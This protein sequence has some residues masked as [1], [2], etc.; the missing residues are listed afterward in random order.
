[1]DNNLDLFKQLQR[2]KTNYGS[3]TKVYTT[4]GASNHSQSDRQED[5]YYATPP[6]AV[7]QLLELENFYNDILEPCCG[8]G[9]ISQTLIDLGYNVE[10]SDLFDRGF[11]NKTASIF[12]L[13]GPYDKDII[14]N[15]PY[16]LAYEFVE[17][18]LELVTE[19]HKVAMFLKLTFLETPRRYYLFKKYPIK[20]IYVSSNRL[21][22]AKNG[23]FKHV[24]K[25]GELTEGSAVCYAWFIW[26]KGYNGPTI[27]DHFNYD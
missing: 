25:D 14:T 18:C 1:M 4:I 24:D 7:K 12:D 13:T 11:G 20:K 9:H 17:K 5:D 6:K 10:S 26:E 3:E 19:G 21:G 23:D 2:G 16:K 27:L 15:P 8:G 22:C